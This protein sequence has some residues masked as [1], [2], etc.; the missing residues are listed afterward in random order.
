MSSIFSE[1]PQMTVSAFSRHSLPASS[2][3]PVLPWWAEVLALPGRVACG[4]VER[5]HRRDAS[6]RLARM[7][8]HQLSDI[9][10]R[11]GPL[12]AR[13]SNDL[14]VRRAQRWLSTPP[15]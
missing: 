1:E 3:A 6:D 4:L 11:K 7:T 14:D 12:D 10:L 2:A 5:R 15:D 8:D 9:G 13:R